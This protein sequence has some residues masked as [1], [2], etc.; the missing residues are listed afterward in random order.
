M[1]RASTWAFWAKTCATTAYFT[2]ESLMA[3]WSQSAAQAT[4]ADLL[5]F[6]KIPSHTLSLRPFLSLFPTALFLNRV[7]SK[8]SP[9]KS[10]R[11]SIASL[12]NIVVSSCHRINRAVMQDYMPN[13]KLFLIRRSHLFWVKF[14]HRLRFL[15]RKRVDWKKMWNL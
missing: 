12:Y 11:Y 9:T 8:I 5:K 2:I 3:C 7:L 14:W 10:C 15:S 4:Y 1:Q 13:K 6:Y